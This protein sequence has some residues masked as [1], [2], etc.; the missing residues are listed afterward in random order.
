MM[1]PV[2]RQTWLWVPLALYA[3]L[4][5]YMSSRSTAPGSSFF[6]FPFGD[7][8]GHALMFGVLA[9][10]IWRALRGSFE[11]SPSAALIATTVLLAVIYGGID[12]IH[13]SYVPG[14]SSDAWDLAADALGAMAITFSLYLFA[15]SRK[16]GLEEKSLGS[17]SQGLKKQGR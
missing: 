6:T 16:K 10:L 14:R 5:W 11:L 1:R 3:G 2:L 12:E 13:Q 7:K 9:A 8:V 15:A 4:I 17:E